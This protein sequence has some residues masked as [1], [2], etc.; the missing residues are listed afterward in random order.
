MSELIPVS[1]LIGSGRLQEFVK[2]WEDA[3]VWGLGIFESAVQYLVR[4]HH[5]ERI[6]ALLPVGRW[7][8]KGFKKQ[9][10][11]SALAFFENSLLIMQFSHSKADQVKFSYNSV[12]LSEQVRTFKTP[13]TWR[14]LRQDVK[15]M[16]ALICP[17]GS[18]QATLS[19]TFSGEFQK[20]VFWDEPNYWPEETTLKDSF[21]KENRKR[22]V[23]ERMH[24]MTTTTLGAIE[25]LDLSESLWPGIPVEL[26]P[27]GAEA[28]IALWRDEPTSH[29]GA[30]SAAGVHNRYDVDEAAVNGMITRLREAFDPKPKEAAGGARRVQSPQVISSSTAIRPS[31]ATLPTLSSTYLPVGVVSAHGFP[32]SKPNFP[33]D[34]G[35][36]AVVVHADGYGLQEGQLVRVVLSASNDHI[37][38][39]V[40]DAT[41][42]ILVPASQY[43]SSSYEGGEATR[44]AGLM[45][46]GFG[47][48]GAAIGIAGAAA[49][50]KLTRRTRIETLW[51]MTT[52]VGEITL[53]TDGATP[54]DI[55][56][57]LAPIR[58]ASR[59]A[60]D[61]PV[62]NATPDDLVAKLTKLAEMRDSGILSEEEFA[63]AKAKIL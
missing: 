49:I 57:S 28:N 2:F 32:I 10:E 54:E 30:R 15:G 63:A 8:G 53:Y 31:T 9:V 1:S 25:V 17:V 38:M 43:I 59:K 22:A 3:E 47:L 21:R 58:T 50:N 26:S 19:F 56:R 34:F 39:I 12:D 51:K 14:I 18:A 16:N 55:E 27:S 33:P 62:V 4:S 20:E 36:M 23:A 44:D 52:A 11:L 41:R 13:D 40:G 5:T 6:A 46:G 35:L 37:G 45:G 42:A 61:Q 60:K 29:L 24:T 7:N 48:A